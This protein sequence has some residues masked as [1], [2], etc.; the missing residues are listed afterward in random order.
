MVLDGTERD[1]EVVPQLEGSLMSIPKIIQYGWF[2]RNPKPASVL[3]CIA[4]WKKY[5]P[6]YEIREWTEDS[7]DVNGNQY[8][9]EAY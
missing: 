6:D 1:N 2:G 3:R 7:F 9:R 5:C 4:S 8:C